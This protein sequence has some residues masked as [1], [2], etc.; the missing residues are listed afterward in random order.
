MNPRNDSKGRQIGAGELA[1]APRMK[2]PAT[3]NTRIARH[4]IANHPVRR[5]ILAIFTAEPELRASAVDL[6]RHPG[7]DGV[8]RAIDNNRVNYHC[9]VL[10]ST[11]LLVEVDRIPVRG[12]VKRILALTESGPRG[13]CRR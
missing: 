9:H 7:M 1:G 11:G 6:L 12:S 10:E 4:R 3:L 2:R 8:S 5:A 13:G